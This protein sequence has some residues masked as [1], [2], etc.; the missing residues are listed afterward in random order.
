MKAGGRVLTKSIRL[1]D[2]E[3]QE[4]EEVVKQTGEVEAS[5]LKRAALRGLREER[6]DRA[7]L[8]YLNGASSAEAAAVA[9]LP[10]A[11]FL[12]VLADR[13]I[14]L[15]DDPSVAPEELEALGRLLG[16]DKLVGV[17]RELGGGGPA[18][19]TPA[20]E[21]RYPVAAR[22]TGRSRRRRS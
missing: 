5:V 22:S 18:A 14:S 10:R 3:S 11:R 17:A 20:A 13:G 15:L 7:I 4:L 1:T 6:E 9:R 19:P 16:A 12:D 21:V 2:E 8:L